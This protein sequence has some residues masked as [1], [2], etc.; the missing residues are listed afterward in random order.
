MEAF[1]LTHPG[2][3]SHQPVPVAKR[4]QSSCLMNEY[5]S[6]AKLALEEI[7]ERRHRGRVVE[8]I[9][10]APPCCSYVTVI[11]LPILSEPHFPAT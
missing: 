1:A 5:I 8:W 2:A 7:F 4:R 6:F 9:L 3:P 11:M 10:L